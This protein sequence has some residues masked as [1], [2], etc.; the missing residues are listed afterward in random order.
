MQA[1]LSTGSNAR[2]QLASGDFEDLNKFSAGDAPKNVTVLSIATGSNHTLI[3]SESSTDAGIQR[4]L[5]GA[6]DGSRGQLGP[7]YKEE[8]LRDGRLGQTQFRQISLP[9]EALGLRNYSPKLIAATWETSYLVLTMDG[10]HDIILSMGSNDFGDLGIGKTGVIKDPGLHVVSLSHLASRKG[11]SLE[12]GTFCVKQVATGQR[13]VIFLIHA[14]DPHSPPRKQEVL[15]GWGSA[16][17]GQL[18]QNIVSPGSSL[19]L[20]VPLPALVS[21]PPDALSQNETI[22]MMALGIQHSLFLTSSGHLI[23]LGSNR[24]GQLNLALHPPPG[25]ILSIG[26]TWNGTYAVVAEG[27]ELSLYSS[28]SNTHG[29][30]GQGYIGQ[31]GSG[32]GTVTFSR[33]LDAHKS[34][35]QIACG[36]E[37]VLALVTEYQSDDH[38][39]HELWVWGWN[40]HGNLGTGTTSD[41]S[42]P[43]RIWS[44]TQNGRPDLLM[45]GIQCIKGL[46]AGSGTSWIACQLIQQHGDAH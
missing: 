37:H 21:L 14:V 2:G 3:L 24:K 27:D 33:R 35:V 16:R 8:Q 40:E 23:S 15:V 44:S 25:R 5:W 34:S 6:G 9:L 29:Q 32:V 39:D 17:H 38:L 28:G 46:W 12:T 22:E 31:Q 10:T 11:I 26:S 13:H 41:T 1:L 20:Y 36:T 18:G 45:N 4:Q 7:G 42:T 19:P 43:I 30:L